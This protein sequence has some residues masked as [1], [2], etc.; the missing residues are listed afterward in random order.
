MFKRNLKTAL[1]YLL[2]LFAGLGTGYLVVN[3][4]TWLKAPYVEGNYAAYYPNAQTKVVVY[5]TATCPYCLKTREFLQAKN[6]T[7]V[8]HDVHKSDRAQK[9]L[10]QLGSKA[11]PVVLIGDRQIR[12]FNPAALESALKKAGL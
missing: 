1:M 7:F 5:G 11:V 12:G 2:I 6:I 3:I 4:P 8:D 10:A 9:E